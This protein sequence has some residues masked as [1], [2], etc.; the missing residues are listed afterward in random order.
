[1]DPLSP[2]PPSTLL[3]ILAV[4][5]AAA[6]WS[7]DRGSPT[8]RALAIGL[9]AMGISVGFGFPLNGRSELPEWSRWL[10]L[11]D[12][13]SIIGFLEWIVR[14]RQQVS[15]GQLDP[16]F[17][18][19]VLRVGQLAGVFYGIAGM[20]W[21]EQ[22]VYEF[23]GALG[24]GGEATHRAGF[25][26]F[27]APVLFA[28]LSAAAGG[29]L[30]LRRRP[31][32][33]EQIRAIGYM[34]ATPFLG[35]AMVMPEGLAVIS[36]AV[37]LLLILTATMHY[38]VIQG[39]RGEFMARFL[40]RRV[41]ELVRDRGLQHAM[42]ENNLELTVV[43]VDLRGFTAYSQAQTSV[44][45]VAVL[46]EYYQV[47]CEV[48]ARYDGT[49]KDLAG[50]GI[51]ILIGAPLPVE[52]HAARS[53]EMADGIRAAVSRAAQRWSEGGQ[54]LGVGI[55]IASG[56][57]TVGAIDAGERYEYTAVGPAVNLASRLC[58]EAADGE[59]LTAART[60]ELCGQA[61]QPQRLEP[62]P[63]MR[64]K[65]FPEPVVHHNLRCAVAA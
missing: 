10:A 51:L 29:A 21:P 31:D 9:A 63:A 64:V 23:L 47:A 33:P 30:F 55:G 53:L 16:R 56:V 49:I 27:A 65:G 61:T 58:E 48:V 37:G 25:W 17:G 43:C 46:R 28:I 14:V 54:R 44:Q 35:F 52:D 50:D 20:L 59:V 26:L 12:M 39:Q 22:R 5:M 11:A 34:I 13:L 8:S 38:L 45:V 32:R 18:D 1:M 7:A 40:S 19:R 4:G 2:V 6:F 42:R 3:A 62:R 41:A 15:V 36:M 24:G 57:V 60:L